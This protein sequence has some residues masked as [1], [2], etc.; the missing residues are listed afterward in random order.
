MSQSVIQWIVM[1]YIVDNVACH[2]M[3]N[4]NLVYDEI[5]VTATNEDN[6]YINI[7]LIFYIIH[8]F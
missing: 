6:Y 1:L 4:G 3:E 7:L 5:A 2:H 8:I